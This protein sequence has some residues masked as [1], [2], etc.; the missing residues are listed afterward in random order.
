MP[1]RRSTAPE[2]TVTQLGDHLQKFLLACKKD[3]IEP[4]A[5][6]K[7]EDLCNGST[8]DPK[9]LV[10][11]TPCLKALLELVPGAIVNFITLKEALICLDKQFGLNHGKNSQEQWASHLA[12]QLRVALSHLRKLKQIPRLYAQRTKILGPLTLSSLI[13]LLSMY[14]GGNGQCIDSPDS[15][16]SAS[17]AAPQTP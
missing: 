5:L 10:H 12:G 17:F 15:H 13:E 9:S 11:C 2:L 4:F 16:T 14:T 1:P 6:S 7:Y 3:R 8:V